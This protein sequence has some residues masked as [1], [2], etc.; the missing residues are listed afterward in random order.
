MD[1]G[2]GTTAMSGLHR[3]SAM[4][5]LSSALM[6]SGDVPAAMPDSPRLAESR[7]GRETQ[8]S[9]VAAKPDLVV[10]KEAKEALSPHS[11]QEE[12]KRVAAAIGLGSFRYLGFERPHF[13]GPSPPSP[14]QEAAVAPPATPPSPEIT[15]PPPAPVVAAPRI[16]A[17]A[18]DTAVPAPPRP[19]FAS[20]FPLLAELTGAPPEV[21][22][23]P[24]RRAVRG[25]SA[26]AAL[27]KLRPKQDSGCL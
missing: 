11:L 13:A 12:V 9:S 27:H 7:E 16:A 3:A 18:P 8:R 21:A 20:G 19:L 24:I 15:V 17:P 10:P 14:R 2:A 23:P 25:P 6:L 5:F 1:G 26:F 4:H 22:P